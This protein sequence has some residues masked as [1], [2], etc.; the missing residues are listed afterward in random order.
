MQRKWLV[1]GEER[2]WVSRHFPPFSSV[3]WL[4]RAV[5]RPV[6]Q[7]DRSELSQRSWRCSLMAN[8]NSLAIHAFH[9]SADLAHL[10][11]RKNP[12]WFRLE[13]LEI[14]QVLASQHRK[15]AWWQICVNCR[16]IWLVKAAHGWGG[17][18]TFESRLFGLDWS[19]LRFIR[20]ARPV[21][22]NETIWSQNLDYSF[23]HVHGSHSSVPAYSF[24]VRV[25]RVQIGP[26]L[27]G[28]PQKKGR[29]STNVGTAERE[30]QVNWICED[31]GRLR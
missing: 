4:T 23:D 12:Q 14:P 30:A 28:I 24:L 19:R 2:S 29:T 20:L 18:Q 16:R 8:A 10:C 1:E 21:P 5:V 22:A 9:L 27:L 31:M 11:L 26:P 25:H 17:C 6:D 3:Q 13:L 15:C 7:N